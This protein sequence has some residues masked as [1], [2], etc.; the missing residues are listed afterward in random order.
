[1]APPSG[2]RP[3][4][5]EGSGACCSPPFLPAASSW[6]GPFL[7]SRSAWFKRKHLA[8]EAVGKVLS[9]AHRPMFF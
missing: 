6:F 4:A 8:E 3:G 2:M 5:G 1:M 9:E 7:L